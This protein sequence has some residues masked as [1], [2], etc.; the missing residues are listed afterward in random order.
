MSEI[1]HLSYSSI[2][3]FLD[4]PESWNR[5]YNLKEPTIPTPALVFGTAFHNTVEKHI[6]GQ[7]DLLDLWPTCWSKAI[8]AP[9]F[10]GLDTAEQHYNEGVRILSSKAIQEGIGQI[11]PKSQEHVEKYVELKVPGVPIPIIGYI[12]VILSDGTPADLKTSK[13]SWNDGKASG[14]LQPLFYLA[15][16]NQAKEETNWTFKHIIFVK[17]KEPKFQILEHSHRPAELFFLFE[18]IKRV[19]NGIESGVYPLNPTGWKCNPQYCD[20]YMNCRGRY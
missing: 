6:T 15:A 19:W 5:K 11:Q 13:A 9:V 10:W 4:C 17:T 16:L 7:G 2:S 8:E 3:M 12:D 18:V 14:S 20:F 1:Q